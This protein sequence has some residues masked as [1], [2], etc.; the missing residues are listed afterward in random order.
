MKPFGKPDSVQKDLM[1]NP[2]YE[3]ELRNAYNEAVNAQ[4]TA[5]LKNSGFY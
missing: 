5:I 4:I 1:K 3:E 2:K